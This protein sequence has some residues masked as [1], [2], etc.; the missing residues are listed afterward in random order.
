MEP[1]FAQELHREAII[2]RSFTWGHI[3][4]EGYS[5]VIQCHWPVK[6]FF[7]LITYSWDCLPPCVIHIT[8]FFFILECS[9]EVGVNGFH[10]ISSVFGTVREFFSSDGLNV[11]LFSVLLNFSKEKGTNLLSP[12]DFIYVGPESD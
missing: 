3:L 11:A 12:F 5:Q 7:E 9:L 8:Y 1:E 6:C 4:K 10:G 2:S